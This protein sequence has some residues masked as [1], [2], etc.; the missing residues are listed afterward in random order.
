[1]S[2]TTSEASSDSGCFDHPCL[3]L[4]NADEQ[5]SISSGPETFSCVTV[6]IDE[7]RT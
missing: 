5:G 4:S 1:M 3:A 7:E 6:R 2:N